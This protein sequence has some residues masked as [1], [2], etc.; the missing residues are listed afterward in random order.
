[1][2]N[3]GED[4]FFLQLCSLHRP[5]VNPVAFARR[6]LIAKVLPLTRVNPLR[7][8]ENELLMIQTN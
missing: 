7:I 2:D 6:F 1:M 4:D 8:E 3:S 5:F